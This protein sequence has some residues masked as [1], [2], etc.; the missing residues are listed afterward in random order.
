VIRVAVCFVLAAVG[1]VAFAPPA[2]PPDPI[3]SGVRIAGIGAGGLDAEQARQLVQRAYARPLR[4]RLGKRG[5]QVSP[6]RFATEPLVEDAVTKAMR[7]DENESVDVRVAVDK[8]RVR[9]YVAELDRRFSRPA[10]DAE[11]VGFTRGRPAISAEQWG[12]S[13]RRATMVAAI[14][15]TLRTRIRPRLPVVLKPLKPTM[16]RAR[17]GP[18]VVIKRDS[19]RLILFNGTKT[20]RAFPVA[21]GQAAYPTPTGN[22]A[23]ADKQR[24]PWWRPPPD[25]EWAQG[26]KPIP[27]GPGNPLGTRW[28]GL[29]APL[30][31]IH[32]TPDAASIGYSASHGCIRM[33]ISDADWLFDHVD[34]GTPVLILAA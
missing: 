30:V 1:A 6:S 25:S 26:A 33:Y 32:G 7:A 24:N 16:S 11:V 15:R 19:K 21:T 2:G 12:Q 28:M 17:F 29:T 18:V 4:F 27:P 20:V 14:T 31:G 3:A 34:L 13:V 5:W 22:F 10:V 9:S 8:S 23:I